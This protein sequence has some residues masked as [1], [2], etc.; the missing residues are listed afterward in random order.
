MQ[1][2]PAVPSQY[3]H[4]DKISFSGLGSDVVFSFQSLKKI[5][6]KGPVVFPVAHQYSSSA[7]GQHCPDDM[8]GI[9]LDR[10][11]QDSWW[12]YVDAGGSS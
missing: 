5:R 3:V 7:V 4:L 2:S 11:Y 1:S 12:T 8:S 6:S 9:T 10:H